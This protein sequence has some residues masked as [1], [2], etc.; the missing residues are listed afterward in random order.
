[1]IEKRS[2]ILLLALTALV[3]FTFTSCAS[4]NE[5]IIRADDTVPV[6]GQEDEIAANQL[7]PFEGLTVTFDGISPYCTISWNDSKCSA[8]VQ[9]Y[10]DYSLSP[11]IITTEGTFAAGDSVTVYASLRETETGAAEYMLTQT[12]KTYQVQEV[13]EY[14]TE[15]T[16]D[17]D[18]EPFKQAAADYLASI[19]AWSVGDGD[20]MGAGGSFL[21]KAEPISYDSYFSA[22]K[23]NSQAKFSNGADYFNKISMTYSIEIEHT[24]GFWGD[25]VEKKTQYFAIEAKNIVRYPDGRLGWGTQD[26]ASLDFE[27]QIDGTNLE[28][29]V[30]KN[31]ISIKSDYNVSTITDQLT[32]GD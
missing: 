12:E 5:Y 1:M 23:L 11:D 20:P 9:Q 8:E 13:P 24:A 28:S 7:D 25:E 4:Q 3:L 15:I 32:V 30:N 2:R 22:L 26:P 16:A 29:L 17:M 19:T 18:L 10:V 6:G 14:I 31:I 21:S 27:H